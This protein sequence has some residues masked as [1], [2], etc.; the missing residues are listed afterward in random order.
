M[1][2]AKK[3]QRISGYAV[4][5]YALWLTYESVNLGLGPQGQP[6]PGFLGFFL[7]LALII[8]S[9]CLIFSNRGAD[10]QESNGKVVRAAR[11]WLKPL[12]ALVALATFA[13]L[14]STLGAVLTMV[15]FF[16]F[17]AK[18]LERQSWITAVLLAICGTASFYGLFALLLRIPLPRGFLG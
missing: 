14:I 5:T 12:L 3:W 8:A 6:G 11:T 4:L 18:I 16:I 2:S 9:V 17:W 1:S 13:A 10:Q 15:L 7:G